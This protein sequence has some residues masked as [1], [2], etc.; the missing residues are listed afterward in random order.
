MFGGVPRDL[1]AR[2]LVRVDEPLR[3]VTLRFMERYGVPVA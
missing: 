3:E 1:A 2:V